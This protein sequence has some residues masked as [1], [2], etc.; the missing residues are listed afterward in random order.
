M[1]LIIINVFL[2]LYLYHHHI[3]GV[4]L[5]NLVNLVVNHNHHFNHIHILHYFILLMHR[6]LRRGLLI[7][8]HVNY[9]LQIINFIIHFTFHHVASFNFINF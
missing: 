4:N 1:I 7:F 8:H 9:E 5:V 2:I 3:R 6:H